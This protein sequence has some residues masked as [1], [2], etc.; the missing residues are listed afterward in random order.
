M[1]FSAGKA[2]SADVGSGGWQP[3]AQPWEWIPDLQ[4]VNKSLW[5][6]VGSGINR[7]RKEV[8]ATRFFLIFNAKRDTDDPCRVPCNSGYSN[9]LVI[10]AM[11][12]TL[13]RSHWFWHQ[14]PY[15]DGG[16]KIK[17]MQIWAT[18]SA[19]FPLRLSFIPRPPASQGRFTTKLYREQHFKH[20][21]TKTNPCKKGNNKKKKRQQKAHALNRLWQKNLFRK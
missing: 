2:L 3:P 18:C 8:P 6:T 15:P 19:T 11:Q 16:R 1:A 13:L 10:P 9:S 20:W 4:R 12:W 17:I 7:A 5:C 21:G 14:V